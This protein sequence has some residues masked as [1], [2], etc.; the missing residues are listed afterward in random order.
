[1][2]NN[3]DNNIDVYDGRARL[4]TKLSQVI[5]IQKKGFVNSKVLKHKVMAGCKD[6]TLFEID[7]QTM[8]IVRSV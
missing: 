3:P 1:M 8:L 5:N 7:P 4:W 2:V 6:G